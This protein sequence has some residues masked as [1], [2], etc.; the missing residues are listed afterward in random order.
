MQ[1]PETYAERCQCLA[2][3]ADREGFAGIPTRFIVDKV[4][5]QTNVS[6]CCYYAWRNGVSLL[7]GENS[8]LAPDE[9][10][11]ARVELTLTLVTGIPRANK[12][13]I[14]YTEIVQIYKYNS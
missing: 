4:P 1:A 13:N 8:A 11:A 3:W 14:P 6:D 12:G 5:R 9:A 10:D 2:Y 7:I